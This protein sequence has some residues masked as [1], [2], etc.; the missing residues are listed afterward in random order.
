[1]NRTYAPDLVS[2]ETLAFR[3]DCSVA[4]IERLMRA[5]ALPAPVM[6]G[7]LMRWDF[8]GVLAF[9][10]RGNGRAPGVGGAGA[11]QKLA[12]N[13]LPGPEADPFLSGVERLQPAQSK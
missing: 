3:L 9:I 2:L 4:E 8:E 7:D 12:S 6:I 11:R 5:G 10:R 1:M 13:G